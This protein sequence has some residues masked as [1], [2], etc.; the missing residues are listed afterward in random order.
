MNLVY[1]PLPN[2]INNVKNDKALQFNWYM[3]NKALH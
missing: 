2:F 1:S 3:K